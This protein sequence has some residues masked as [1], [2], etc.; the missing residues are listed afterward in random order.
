LS[1][2]LGRRAE[3]LEIPVQFFSISPERVRRTSALDG[4]RAIAVAVRRRMGRRRQPARPAA[5]P[6][7]PPTDAA[8]QPEAWTES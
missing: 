4:L 8:R 1:A 6:A 5:R 3:M 7:V 2:L